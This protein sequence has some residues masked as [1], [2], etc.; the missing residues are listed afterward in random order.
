MTGLPAQDTADWVFDLELLHH[1]TTSTCRT[2]STDA[3]RADR[4]RLWQVEVPRQ[5]FAH[6]FLLHQILA[7][8][9]SHL[10][11]LH[12]RS[13]RAYSLRASHHQS[14]ALQGMR[15]ALAHI[16]P[17]NC[18]ALF[19]ASS[20][21]FIAS[22]AALSAPQPQPQLQPQPPALA[23]APTGIHT[24]FDGFDSLNGLNGSG[25]GSGPTV[26]D[27]VDVFL[28]VKGIGS[29]LHSSQALLRTGPLSDLFVDRGGADQASVTLHR[30]VLALDDLA[31]QIAALSA[32]GEGGEG[33]VDAAGG[34]G[35]RGEGERERE[36]DD[37]RGGAERERDYA[38]AVD[39]PGGADAA[40]RAVVG[41]EVARLVA[42][43]RDCAAKTT[44]PEYRVVAAW[45]I[46]M[47][48]GLVPLLRARNQTALAL[49]SYYCV[50]FH[51]AETQ[52]YW[53]MQG[54]A[55]GVVRDI[56]RATGP[57]WNRHSAWALA[58]ITGHAGMS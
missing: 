4:Q 14:L 36:R 19:A 30:V 33:A 39:A 21:L 26:D 25:S 56:A 44:N 52:G 48:D 46:L 15:A 49:L 55:A 27:L 35:G 58:W 23:P 7:I 54:W 57:P 12:P 53:F 32:E 2:F 6:V 37:G 11:H 29:V 10:A 5:A 17:A 28:L 31:L 47:A 43:I 3:T 18:H 40:V 34:M 24:G 20:L 51:A 16:S 8:A 50:V 13:R 1:F 41:G 22:L 42:V 9:A 45:P 38:R